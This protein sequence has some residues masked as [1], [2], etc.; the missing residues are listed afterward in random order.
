MREYAMYK[1]T[2]FIQYELYRMKNG[3]GEFSCM[4]IFNISAESLV[5]N[6]LI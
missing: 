1:H 3:P 5:R 2:D 6:H 4:R